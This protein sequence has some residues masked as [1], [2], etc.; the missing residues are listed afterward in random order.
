MEGLVGGHAQISYIAWSLMWLS[1]HGYVAIRFL[2][3]LEVTHMPF[4]SFFP[5]SC[6][7]SFSVGVQS[8]VFWRR[9]YRG[10]V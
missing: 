4:S 9:L 6:Y 8:P 2:L 5:A 7:T 3:L 1:G 10:G